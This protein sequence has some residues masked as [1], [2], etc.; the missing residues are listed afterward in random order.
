MFS[1]MIQMINKKKITPRKN[2]LPLKALF[3]KENFSKDLNN[4]KKHHLK[5]YHQEKPKKN[6][7]SLA[8]IIKIKKKSQKQL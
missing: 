6:S 1:I 7:L 3:P 5:N 4:N 2:L 8:Q